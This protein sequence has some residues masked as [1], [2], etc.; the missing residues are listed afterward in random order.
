MFQKLL[1]NSIDDI[2]LVSK[3][4]PLQIFERDGTKLVTLVEK[5]VKVESCG[6]LQ[7]LDLIQA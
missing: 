2:R 6:L 3:F 7:R 4:K 1:L 5:L